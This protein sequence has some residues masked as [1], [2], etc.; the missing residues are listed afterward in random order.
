VSTAMSFFVEGRFTS[1]TSCGP[2]AR[3]APDEERLSP[4]LRY[5]VSF[6]PVASRRREF[7]L[8]STHTNG[9]RTG[10]SAQKKIARAGRGISIGTGSAGL[11]EAIGGHFSEGVGDAGD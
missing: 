8:F 7:L 10:E 5:Q 3:T 1:E 2:T 9:Q 11:S 6:E 4:A